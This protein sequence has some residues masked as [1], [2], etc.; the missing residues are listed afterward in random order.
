MN[1]QDIFTEARILT[2]PQER[3]RF[4]QRVCGGDEKLLQHIQKLLKMDERTVPLLDKH[5]ASLL[6]EI[7]DGIARDAVDETAFVVD[8]IRALLSPASR[9]GSLGKLGHYDVEEVI[10]HGGFGIVLRAFDDKLRRTVA[11]KVLAPSLATTSPPRKRFLRE[12]RSA[13][14]VRHEHVVQIYGVEEEPI[15]YLTMEYIEGKTLQQRFDAEGPLGVSEVVNLGI[16]IAQGLQAAHDKG[17]VHRDIKPGNIMIESGPLQNVKITDF[18]LARTADDAS[19]THSGTF[20][21]TPMFMAPEQA[22]GGDVDNRADLFSFGSVLY[23]MCCGR[24]PFRAPNTLAVLK[25]VAGETPRPIQQV[26]PEIPS[27]LCAII[28]RLHHKNPQQRY[29]SA[30]DVIT[31]LQRCLTIPDP[32]VRRRKR[33]WSV[34]AVAAL[35]VLTTLGTFGWWWKNE[36][37]NRSNSPVG[38]ATVPGTIGNQPEP[39]TSFNKINT[40]PAAI[41]SIP[42]VQMIQMVMVQMLALNPELT[43]NEIQYK[44]E[45]GRIVHLKIDT[46]TVIDI[47]PLNVL[48]DLKGLELVF[49]QATRLNL[50]PLR[51]MKNLVRLDSVG[52]EISDLSPLQDLP[53]THLTIWVW[54]GALKTGRSDLSPL[55]G[56][57]LHYLNCGWSAVEDLSPLIGM[58][59]RELTINHTYVSDLSPLKGMALQTFLCENSRV[60]DLSP[61]AGIP[62][63]ILAFD[64]SPVEDTSPLHGLPVKQLTM[65]YD[66]KKHRELLDHLPNLELLN[67]KPV[68]E[69]QSKSPVD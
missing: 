17:I 5:P 21:G 7:N 20:A 18:G 43:E 64:G 53:L 14:A 61:L 25:R 2:D 4:L 26:M 46:K 50:S 69:F 41:A 68:A 55:R 11:I 39:A 45:D 51:N 35:I 1:E 10:G 3:T 67:G 8:Q 59:L 63:E 66:P 49:S 28:S 62:L 6:Q 9:E 34:A 22:I 12:A 13:A 36:E 38:A 29:Q 58:P 48:T 57:S 56:M 19:I 65:D 24:P 31:D 23:T 54:G 30:K 27:A 40:P 32:I 42:A 60:R 15:P 47:S 37:E 52:A 44:V 16:Q 33:Q